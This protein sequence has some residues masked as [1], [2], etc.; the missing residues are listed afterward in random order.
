MGT[1]SQKAGY[2][3][4]VF[5]EVTDRVVCMVRC[6]VSL[7]VMRGVLSCPLACYIRV[8]VLMVHGRLHHNGTPE[9]LA[10]IAW[11]RPELVT[12]LGSMQVLSLVCA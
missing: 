12:V 10:A 8:M 7:P 6:L 5:S 4:L 1:V 9:I 2:E 11:C 3:L